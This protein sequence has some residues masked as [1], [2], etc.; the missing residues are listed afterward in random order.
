MNAVAGSPKEK[1]SELLPTSLT[2]SKWMVEKPENRFL[3]EWIELGR[4]LRIASD[5]E[6]LSLI[7]SVET[8]LEGMLDGET[9]AS[10]EY[11]QYV[12]GCAKTTLK[13]ARTE[14]RNRA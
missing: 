7:S 9:L 3:G 10:P 11:G 12:R 4:N 2:W 6:I 13:A 8:Y 14:L 5:E 1:E